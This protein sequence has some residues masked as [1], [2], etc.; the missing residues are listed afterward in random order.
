MRFLL[1]VH[2]L[3][4]CVGLGDACYCPDYPPNGCDSQ[5]SILGD[6]LRRQ[7]QRPGINGRSVYTVRV[8]QIYKAERPLP[9]VW[10]G[11]VRISA[12]HGSSTCGVILTTGRLYVISGY[13]Q[14]SSLQ[15][16]S[17]SY[18]RQ[19]NEIPFSERWNLYC[20]HF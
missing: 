11:I 20:R 17:C 6:V 19:W 2:L 9:Y 1:A 12:Y 7:V 18:V 3:V 4:L 5:Y 14:G 8:L 13:Y 16:S 15:T 10:P